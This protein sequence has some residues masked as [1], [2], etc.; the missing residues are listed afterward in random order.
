MW[1]SGTCW[2]VP[3][4]C[5]P[6]MGALGPAGPTEEARGQRAHAEPSL[7]PTLRG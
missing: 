2:E 1:S 7:L 5:G 3:C 4:R 6:E